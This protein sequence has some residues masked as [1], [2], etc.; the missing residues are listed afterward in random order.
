MNLN[1][2]ILLTAIIGVGSGGLL[3]CWLY[4][5]TKPRIMRPGDKLDCGRTIVSV[6][7]SDAV[8]PTYLEYVS[9]RVVCRL[10]NLGCDFFNKHR[11]PRVAKYFDDLGLRFCGWYLNMVTHKSNKRKQPNASGSAAGD[12]KP[13]K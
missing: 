11:I 7:V 6:T 5:W 4:W 2:L 8:H 3:G 13:P 12:Q 9:L 1:L 10:S